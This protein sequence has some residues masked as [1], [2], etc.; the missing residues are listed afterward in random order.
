VKFLIDA[1]SPSEGKTVAAFVKQ[2][3]GGHLHAAIGTHL[4]MDHIGGMK[5]VVEQCSIGG[6]YLNLPRIQASR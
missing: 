5:D 1:G 4:D 6:F 2:Y 3:A